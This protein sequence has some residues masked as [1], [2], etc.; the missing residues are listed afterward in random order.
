MFLKGLDYRL[1]DSRILKNFL[2]RLTLTILLQGI[3]I[4]Y[5]NIFPFLSIFCVDII[6]IT[7][8]WVSWITV[9]QSS[10]KRRQWTINITSQK[11]EKVPVF[12][13][14]HE[15]FLW[16]S[17]ACSFFLYFFFMHFFRKQLVSFLE[18]F[19]SFYYVFFFF[20]PLWNFLT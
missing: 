10:I 9:V 13:P 8:C 12:V 7:L 14:D 19:L 17:H 2:V 4:N 6:L 18:I 3:V 11:L 16:F 5:I 1:S 15:F 20:S